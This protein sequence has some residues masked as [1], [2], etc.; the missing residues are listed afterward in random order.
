MSFYLFMLIAAKVT[1]A[2]TP[3]LILA[4]VVERY[5]FSGRPRGDF[6]K[7]DRDNDGAQR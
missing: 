5:V 3:L 4:Y 7:N 2:E 1:A 6:W